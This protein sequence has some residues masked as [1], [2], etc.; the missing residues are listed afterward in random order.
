M[1][2][3]R[4][5]ARR[6]ILDAHG[7]TQSTIDELLA[8][9]AKPFEEPV[10]PGF[11]LA[12]EP[13][14]DVWRSYATDATRDG[15]WE[16]LRRHFVQLR[17]PIR[18]GVS[19]EP[20][21][22]AATRRGQCAAADEEFAPGLALARPDGLHLNIQ[23]TIAG[24]VPILVADDRRDFVAL[25][26]AFSERNEPVDVP[27]SMG[28]C[29]VNGLNNWDRVA[30]YREQWERANPEDADTGWGDEF[31]RFAARKELYHD[32]FISLSRGPDSGAG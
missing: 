32:R 20:A 7:A 11:P 27:P 14:A 1:S 31:T 23:A 26:Q 6:R 25:V 3:A 17:V 29:I 12:D 16:S 24:G 5:A 22:Q 28:A 19:Q 21:Y 4:V 13:H 8:Y 9:S 15:A 10:C 2:D 30:A 18:A